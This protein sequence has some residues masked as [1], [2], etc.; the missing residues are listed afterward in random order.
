MKQEPEAQHCYTTESFLQRLRELLVI[1]Q[2]DYHCNEDEFN[3]RYTT[4]GA[5]TELADTLEGGFDTDDLIHELLKLE[6]HHFS[7]YGYDHRGKEDHFGNVL[8]LV[9][10]FKMP[11]PDGKEQMY[12]KINIKTSGVFC[13]SYHFDKPANIL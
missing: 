8:P 1:G 4:A 12:V 3:D 2:F 10:I 9:W 6:T 11:S 5:M 7:E 13:L